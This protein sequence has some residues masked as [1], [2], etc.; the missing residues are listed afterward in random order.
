MK[1]EHCVS[2][3]AGKRQS[4]IESDQENPPKSPFNKGGLNISTFNKG[5]LNISPL[6]KGDWGN[7]ETK[8]ISS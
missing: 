4:R 2:R 6:C 5:E 7:L 1:K 3:G 8:G